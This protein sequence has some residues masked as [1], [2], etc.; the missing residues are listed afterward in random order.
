MFGQGTV[1]FLFSGFAVVAYFRELSLEFGKLLG[2]LLE[3]SLSGLIIFVKS[4]LLFFY[5]IEREFLS[6]ELSD[7]CF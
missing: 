5:C 1:E 3:L 4:C 7:S 2:S 6:T